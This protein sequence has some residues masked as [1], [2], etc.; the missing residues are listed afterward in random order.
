VDSLQRQVISSVKW[1]T[2]QTVLVAV[3]TGPIFLIVK[4][5]YLSPT[6][7]AYLAI[8]SIVLGL[9]GILGNIGISQSVIQKETITIEESSSLFFFNMIFATILAIMLY[10]LSNSI[11][12]FF[13]MPDLSRLLEVTSIIIIIDAPAQLFRAIFEKNLYFKKISLVD[14]QKNLIMV[15]VST[16][17][18]FL[19]YGV[20][21]VIYG[22]IIS[23]F[24]STMLI[25][26]INYKYGIA[27]I[28][29]YFSLKRLKPFFRFGIFVFGKQAM[30]FITNHM[31]ELIIG[32]FLSPE[33]LGIY[34]FGK[35]MLDRL[36]SLITESFARVFFPTLAK[37]KDQHE[38]LSIAYTKI[39]KYLAFVSFP[40]FI[41]IAITAHLF[42]PLLFGQKWIDSVI[43]FRV[44]SLAVIFL[45]L[46]ANV[47]TSLLYSVNKPNV[48]FFIDLLFN[49]TYL[50]LL[51]IFASKGIIAV[52]RVYVLYVLLKTLCLQYFANSELT[53]NI[54][55]YF[56]NLSGLALISII[57]M[58]VVIIFQSITMKLS[59]LY[60]FIGS[61]T[62][63]ILVYAILAYLF[64]KRILLELRS[65]L[66]NGEIIQ[67]EV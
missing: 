60:E 38:K 24:I 57:M 34:Y 42:V 53:Y 33:V 4:A 20:I 66:Y 3:I 7:F 51:F 2:L 59:I 49:T 25:L 17:F 14:I 6:E 22:N 67:N 5:I 26:L 55:S 1:T 10:F 19:G 48:V 32:Y 23:T 43:V 36:R 62:I 65:V 12:I 39:S 29:I 16:A 11:A 47:S 13:S 18:L 15:F 27:K 52:L 28:R 58:S 31:D 21:S 54:T 35:N 9:N 8:V 46:T 45:V 64:E 40:V 56:R 44:F 30:T 37:I 61:V 63:G 41:G 50:I